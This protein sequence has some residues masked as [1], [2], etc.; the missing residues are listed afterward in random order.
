MVIAFFSSNC[1]RIAVH[2]LT[3]VLLSLHGSKHEHMYNV[4]YKEYICMCTCSMQYVMYVRTINTHTC[5]YHC[6]LFSFFLWQ[7]SLLLKPPFLSVAVSLWIKMYVHTICT[8]VCAYLPTSWTY[9]N[10]PHY[11]FTFICMYNGHT[12]QTYVPHMHIYYSSI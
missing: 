9:V 8:Y 2:L 10:V 7:V 5:T 11:V 4:L 6:K 12:I 1:C 3:C